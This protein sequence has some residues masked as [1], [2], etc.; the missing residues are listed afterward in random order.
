[1]QVATE[2][3]TITAFKLKKWVYVIQTLLGRHSGSML[4]LNDW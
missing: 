2:F 3:R 1:M 4:K